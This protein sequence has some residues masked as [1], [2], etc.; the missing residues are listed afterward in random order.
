MALGR[1]L[2]GGRRK[3]ASL[4]AKEAAQLRK[5]R[6]HFFRRA[7]WLFEK[8]GT[9]KHSRQEHA[10]RLAE[11]QSQFERTARRLERRATDIAAPATRALRDKPARADDVDAKKARLRLEA[12]R[13]LK[14]GV[15]DARAQIAEVV[16]A[17]PPHQ[18]LEDE[19]AEAGEMRH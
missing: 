3:E 6:E 17:G 7:L 11:L 8:D 13:V 1:G 15:A 14:K 9:P 5:A 16:A 2:T 12:C 10:R 4:F 19:A 18:R